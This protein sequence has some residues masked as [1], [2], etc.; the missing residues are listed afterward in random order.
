ML[1]DIEKTPPFQHEM[2]E[3]YVLIY[4]PTLMIYSTETKS[5]KN[6]KTIFI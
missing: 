5:V 1:T 3:N 4:Y 6:P 2:N